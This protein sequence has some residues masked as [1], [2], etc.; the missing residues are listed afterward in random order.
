MNWKLK[1]VIMVG[2]ISVVFAIIYLGFVYFA[3]FI[4]PLLTPFGLAPFANEIVFGVWFM[5]ATLAAYIM[6]KPW[7]AIIAEMLAALI[8][9]M[10]GNF[11]GPMVFISGFIQGLGAEVGFALFRYRRFDLR[12]LTLASILSAVFSFIWG[13]FRNSYVGLNMWY[14]VAMLL[15]RIISAV[16]FSAFMVKIIGDGLA[17]SGAVSNYPI[18]QNNDKS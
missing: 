2:I 3:A 8:E 1:D 6:Q 13:F 14:V 16:V 9:V 18:D 10:M 7:V 12:S 4:R 5:A 11:Y 17:R 15:V